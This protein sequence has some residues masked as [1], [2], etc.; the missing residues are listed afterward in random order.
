MWPIVYSRVRREHVDV[1]LALRIPYPNRER[2]IISSHDLRHLAPLADAI[3]ELTLL[4]ML[5]QRP[6]E[7]GRNYVRFA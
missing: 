3:R 7:E 2:F 4:Q 1:F 6:P 5:C